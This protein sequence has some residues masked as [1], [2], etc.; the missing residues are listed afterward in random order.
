MKFELTPEQV[1]DRWAQYAKAYSDPNPASVKPFLAEDMVFVRG[2]G[3]APWRSR[4]EFLSFHG[5]SLF[6]QYCEETLEPVDVEFLHYPQGGEGELCYFIG[7]VNIRVTAVKDWQD[8][9]D[10]YPT[11]RKGDSYSM[12]DRLIYA[13]NAHGK[14]V[15]ILALETKRLPDR[16]AATT[17]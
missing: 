15:A 1:S 7:T 2:D 12:T 5:P 14:I 4:D 17:R 13:M 16:R 6:R 10:G 3:M 11:V 9:P 8:P